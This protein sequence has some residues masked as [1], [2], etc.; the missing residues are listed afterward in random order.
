M[1]KRFC[2]GDPKRQV[3]YEPVAPLQ[4][5]SMAVERY[6]CQIQGHIPKAVADL[7]HLVAPFHTRARAAFG[8]LPFSREERKKEKKGEKKKRKMRTIL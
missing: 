5:P 4:N 6:R 7:Q 3:V 8:Q 1:E 2:G